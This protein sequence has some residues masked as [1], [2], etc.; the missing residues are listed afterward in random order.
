HGTPLGPAGCTH[1]PRPSHSSFVQTLKSSEHAVPSSL[2]SHS[3][4]ISSHA[5]LHSKNAQGS[6]LWKSQL[7]PTQKSRPLQN[8]PSSQ[9]TKKLA[10]WPHIPRPSQ[11]SSVQ[12]LPSSVHG[13]P[14]G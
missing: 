10:G 14:A 3:A 2:G 13:T 7:P 11:T 8:I 6:P 4:P 5:V 12:T 9:G 1:A